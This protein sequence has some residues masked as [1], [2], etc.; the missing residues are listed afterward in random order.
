LIWGRR[1]D[2]HPFQTG[3]AIATELFSINYGCSA[4][5]TIINLTHNRDP[6]LKATFILLY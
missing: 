2:Y 5:R 3:A 6:F 4:I 1:F